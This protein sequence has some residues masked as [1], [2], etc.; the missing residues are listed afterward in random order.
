MSAKTDRVTGGRKS[1][2]VSPL[3]RRKEEAAWAGTAGAGARA[4]VPRPR[5]RW[6]PRKASPP[7]G[8]KCRSRRR[9]RRRRRGGPTPR[10]CR[11][12]PHRLEIGKQVEQQ[13]QEHGDVD[14]SRFL[15]PPSEQE[16]GEEGERP[17]R[18]CGDGQV[19]RREKEGRDG[20][21]FPSLLLEGVGHVIPV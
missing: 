16:R 15:P 6:T 12:S 1:A 19:T 8:G 2:R 7:P 20:A 9:R 4:E 5:G 10:G 13:V 11:S 21:G 17:V 14:G 3:G 18:R